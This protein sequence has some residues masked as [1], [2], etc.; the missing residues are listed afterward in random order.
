MMEKMQ[1]NMMKHYLGFAALGLIIVL[2]AFGFSLIGGDANATFFSVNKATREAA[3]AG[4]QLAAANVI[5]HS[6]PVWVPS[7]KFLGLSIL[8]GAITMALGAI[9]VSLRELGKDVMANW[10]AEL[11]PGVPEKPR[12]AKAFPLLMM[13]GWMFLLISLV[14]GLALLG[15]VNGYWNH[16]IASELNLAEVGSTLLQQL[17]TITATLPWVNLFKFVGMALLFTAITVALTVVV[18]TL[19]TQEM[20]LRRFV[21]A[22]SASSGN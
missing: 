21:D 9:I 19:Q 5:R 20:V 11:N 13:M 15:T 7:F 16:S 8:L 6:I 14:I 12:S 2:V 1:N 18:R 10:P 22:R 3:G 4:S 17:G